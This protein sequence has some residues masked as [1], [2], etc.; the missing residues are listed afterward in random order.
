M[1]LD[2]IF[3]FSK[4]EAEHLKHMQAVLQRPLQNHLF[5]KAEKCRFHAATVSFFGFVLS[6][7]H[8]EMGFSKVEAVNNWPTLEKQKALQ[9]LLG[10]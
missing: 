1:T 3:F 10:F 8:I 4:S 7:G 5:V 6:A 2:E 9:H